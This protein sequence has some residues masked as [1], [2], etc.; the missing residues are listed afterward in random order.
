[1]KYCKVTFF[2]TIWDYTLAQEILYGNLGAIP[3]TA[4]PVRSYPALWKIRKIA[5]V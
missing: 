4:A 1:M 3:H 2:L 5:S